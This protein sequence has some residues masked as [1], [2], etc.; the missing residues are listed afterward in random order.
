MTMRILLV[1]DEPLGLERLRTILVGESQVEIVGECADGVSAVE[2]IPK[3]R[4]DVLFL[5]IRM[6][7]MDGFEVLQALDPKYLPWTIFVTAYEEHAVKAFEARALDY[8]LKPITRERV[9]QAISRVRERLSCAQP[10]PALQE[11]LAERN[12]LSRIAVPEGN[13]V[14][15]VPTSAID[16]IESA[17][18]YVVMHAGGKSHILRQTLNEM[19]KRLPHEAFFRVSRAAILNVS[20]IIRFELRDTQWHAVLDNETTIPITR[21]RTELEERLR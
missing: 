6:P 3:V 21:G 5:D 12:A 14:I 18:N 7:G 17:A 8:L 10:V 1:D 20:K 13:K 4:P 9:K 11:W 16:W 19:E 2:T 15:F